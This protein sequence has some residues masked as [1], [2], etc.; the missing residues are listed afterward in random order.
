MSLETDDGAGNNW[1]NARPHP[2]PLPRGEGETFGASGRNV[3]SWFMGSV[4]ERLFAALCLALGFLFAGAAL[5]DDATPGFRGDGLCRFALNRY[6]LPKVNEDKINYIVADLLRRHEESFNFIASTNLHVRIRI[7]GTFEGYRNYALTNNDGFEHENLAISN[8]AGFY[9]PRDNEVV[10]WRQRDP[11]YLAN[12]ILHECSH[13]I[14]HQQ[15]RDLP[16]WL[17]EG[18][19]VYFSY[20]VYMRT[21]A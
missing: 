11:T 12:N 5:A 18:C 10:T 19:A 21:G 7:F 4:R 15:Y 2:G 9:S 6:A 8:V 13:A 1:F 14:M 3:A 20:P 16:I 17:D